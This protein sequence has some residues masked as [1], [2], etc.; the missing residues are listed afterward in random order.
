NV[1]FSSSTDIDNPVFLNDE[2]NASTSLNVPLTPGLHSFGMY[3]EAAGSHTDSF[4]LSLYFDGATAAPGISAVAAV[5]GLPDAFVA[6]SHS[7][8]L[9]LLQSDGFVPNASTLSFTA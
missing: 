2:N 8:G 4:T 9:G 5:N 6:A 3:G 1:Y 7:D